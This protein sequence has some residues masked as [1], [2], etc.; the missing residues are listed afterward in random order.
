MHRTCVSPVLV[1]RRTELDRLLAALAN[2]AAG[3]P[4]RLLIAGEA[5]IGKT[6][7]LEE[8]LAAARRDGAVTAV[9]GCLELGAEGLPFAPF[10]TALRTLHRSLPAEVAE[11]AAGREAELARLLPDLAPAPPAADGDRYDAESK[12]RLFE[13]TGQLLERLARDRTV[14]LAVEDLHW[15]DRSTRELLGYLVRSVRSTRLAVLATY[16]SDDVHRRHPLRPFLAELERLRTVER[17]DLARLTR[18]EVSGQLAAI[19][20][21]PPAPRLVDEVFRRSDGNPF[22]VE[23]LLALTGEGGAD[24][25]SSLR[26]LLL[27]RVETLPEESQRVLR[28]A[29]EA[30]STVEFGLLL[31]VSGLGE[32]E[33]LAALRP[34][35][36]AGLLRPAEDTADGYRFRHA[37]LREAVGDDLLP[38]ERPRLNRRYAEALEAD[39][40]LARPEERAG[41]LASYWHR[42]GDAARALPAALEA[43]GEACHRHAFAE[44]L[45]MLRRAIELWDRVP[46]EDLPGLTGGWAEAYPA[47]AESHTPA[48]DYLDLLAEAAVAARLDDDVESSATLVKQ[49][50]RTLDDTRDP[51]RAAWFWLEASWHTIAAGRGD[52]WRELARAIELVEDRPPSAVKADVLARAALWRML[53]TPDEEGLRLGEQA[54]DLARHVAAHEVE[55]QARI[56]LAVLHSDTGDHDR[57][58]RELYGLREEA[59]RTGAPGPIARVHTNLTSVLCLAGRFREAIEA[60]RIGLEAAARAGLRDALASI[61]QNMVDALLSVGEWDEAERR[62][63][64]TRP[65][66]GQARSRA[67]GDLVAAYLAMYRGDLERTAELFAR[68]RTYISTEKLE[69]QAEFPVALV[70]AWVARQRR[71]FDEARTVVRDALAQRPEF[72]H[73]ASVWALM[74]SAAEG[75]AEAQGDPAAAAGRARFLD[76]LAAAAAELP[77]PS[78]LARAD[79]AAFAAQLARARGG[80]DAGLWTAALAALEPVERPYERARLSLRLAETLLASGGNRERAAELLRPARE[81]A[82]R[83][84]AEPLLTE[85][86][87]VAARA[88]LSLTADSDADSV[89][90]D[91]VEAFGLTA[92]ERDVLRL[93]SAGRTN[94]QIAEELFISP[95]TASVHV[96]NLM[97]KLGVSGRGEAAALAHRMRL[98][99]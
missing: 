77:A 61:G 9:G 19:T 64:Q 68:S 90:G 34:A 39:P 47:R 28:L 33:L 99:T 16:R 92:R 4:Q 32:E 24:L 41:R 29:A 46:R 40:A 67:G 20:G 45:V 78:T 25:S 97:A 17:I 85:V 70:E 6:R 71:R 52:G 55:L 59:A 15:S 48:D 82:V 83:L 30:G 26:D 57:A 50:L 8:F 87:A 44:Q 31:A 11:A 86:D 35:V 73:E 84:G 3:T 7:L 74:A 10:A 80:A 93:V 79:A 38:G 65:Y 37:L 66:Q 13:L 21:R 95:K 54:A 63:V 51:E 56:T 18:D 94:R 75:E 58:V 76:D 42:A 5:G 27:V 36:D 98:F 96:S 89:S 23:E 81:L 88:R 22:F 62:L 53:N 49:A 72:G 69:P 14:V 1:G 2:A 91:P 12:G 60:G 43:A